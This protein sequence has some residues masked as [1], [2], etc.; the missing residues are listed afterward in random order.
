MKSWKSVGKMNPKDI[1]GER[2][3][4]AIL[5]NLV[6]GVL[7]A[8][9]GGAF[10]LIQIFQNGDFNSIDE[11]LIAIYIMLPILIANLVFSFLYFSVL[12]YFMNGQTL[13]K[14]VFRIKVLSK[15]YE[16]VKFYQHVIRNFTLWMAILSAIII[17]YIPKDMENTEGMIAFL[18]SS[19]VIGFITSIIQIV[20]LITT[21]VSKEGMGLHDRFAQTRVVPASFDLMQQKLAEIESM[22]SWIEVVDVEKEVDP[23]AEQNKPKPKQVEE[24]DD[25]PW[26]RR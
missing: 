15:E 10:S 6:F 25:D 12:P 2:L 21:L 16:P 18:A 19:Y 1:R 14:K 4:A 11:S 22:K 20:I 7:A 23:W 26:A 3:V 9:V 5:D 13:F 17:F 24:D 8:I